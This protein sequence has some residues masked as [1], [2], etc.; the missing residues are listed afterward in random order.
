MSAR[1]LTA[2]GLLAGFAYLV[3]RSIYSFQGASAWLSVPLFVVEVLGFLGAGVLVWALWPMPVSRPLLITDVI[4]PV[5]TV[6][7]VVRVSHQGLHEVRATLL[8][9][10]DVDGV[11][12]VLVVDHSGRPEVASLATEFQ[13]VYAATDPYDHNGLRVMAAAVR[14]AEFLLI[15]AGDIPTQDI[16]RRLAGDLAD[17]RIAVVQGLGASPSDDSPEHGPNRRHELLFER[18]ALNPAL[19]RRKVAVWL[20]SGSLVRTDALREVPMVDSSALEAHW[21]ATSALHAAGWRISAPADVPVVAHRTV[22]DD[23]VVYRDR[24]HRARAARKMLVGPYGVLRLGS[25]DRRQRLAA[26]AWTVRPLSSL[27]RVVFMMVLCASLLAGALPMTLTS[28]ALLTLWSPYF[29]YTGI[30][31]SLLSGWTLRPGDRTRWSLHNIGATFTSLR[32]EPDEHRARRPIVHL[33]S[34]QYGASLV[35]AIVALS[36][37]LVL[38]G[39]SDRVTHTLGVLPQSA[40]LAMLTV[41]LWLLAISLD[42]LRVLARR[43]TFRRATRVGAALSATL[44]ERAVSIIDLTSLG[45]GVL[46]QTGLEVG[47]RLTLESAVPT[48]T[49]V[50]SMQVPVV[51]RNV[52]YLNSGEWRIGLE[53]GELDDATANALA[54]YCIIEPM[55]ECMGTMPGSSLVEPRPIAV[56]HFDEPAVG[57]GR[58]AMRLV[59]S[60]ALVGAIASALPAQ[61]EASQARNHRWS[62]VV[63]EVADAAGVEGAVVT[64]VCAADHGIDAKWGTADDVYLPPVS[65]TTDSAGAYEID[66]GGGA[67]WSYVAPPAGFRP[68]DSRD[69]NSV[70]GID[71]GESPLRSRIFV[72]PTSGSGSVTTAATG[73]AV[74]DAIWDDQNGNGVRDDGEPGMPGVSVTLYDAVGSVAA[75]TVTDQDGAFQ[76]GDVVAGDYRVGVSNL[77]D[78]FAITTQT[79]GADHTVDSDA[80]PYTGRSALVA[81][82]TDARLH[83]VDVGLRAA[84]GSPITDRAAVVFPTPLEDQIAEMGQVRS[85][86]SLV[87]LTLIGI[88]AASLLAGL[89]RPRRL[90]MA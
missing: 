22:S 20:G 54:E 70:R 43:V 38:R 66:L 87:V 48:E 51:V 31:M 49:G 5:D 86:L 35:F 68:A 57:A 32:A 25:F 45:A 81:L 41:S 62:G 89:A 15:D 55:W 56:D 44:G 75:T 27:R 40:L 79:R 8:A 17:E 60:L 12:Q 59:S 34:S 61:V 53:F 10:R 80:D 13:A 29:V 73:A 9:L 85:T 71:L 21:L 64:A 37:V 84:T 69:A 82:G 47:E 90:A 65:T 1:V 67:C 14:T 11:D 2:I 24:V 88:L 18:S 72:V 63:Q 26:L 19:G 16:V 33:P 74:G 50:T 23:R 77:P 58:M 6:D 3:W 83:V 76:F 39:L 36:V 7:A 78:G 4:S 42:V 52:R 30:G 28:F 46:S